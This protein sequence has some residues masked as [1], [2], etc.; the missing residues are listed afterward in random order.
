MTDGTPACAAAGF[1]GDDLSFCRSGNAAQSAALDRCDRVLHVAWTGDVPG[2]YIFDN[3]DLFDE[4]LYGAK[5]MN[6]NYDSIR[7]YDDAEASQALKRVAEAPELKAISSFLYGPGHEFEDRLRSLLRNLDTIDRFQAMIMADTIQTILDKTSSGLHVSGLE[8][9]ENGRKHVL[10]SNHRDIILDPAILQLILFNN[11]MSTTEIAVGDNLIANSFIEDIFRSNRMIK[12]ER[13]G[14]PREKYMSSMRLS[15]YMRDKV[16]SGDCSVWIAQRNGRSKDGRDMT[17]QGLLK[18]LEMSGTGDFVKDFHELAI[19][20]IAVSYQFEPCDFLKARELYISRRCQYVK[21]PGED[22]VSILTGVRQFK[23]RISFRFCPELS[24]E[25]LYMCAAHD[26]NG[27]FKVM[28]SL[29]DDRICT[30]YKLWDTNYIACDI[31]DGSDAYSSMYTPESRS[32]FV[33]YMEK[34]L[35][36]IVGKDPDVDIEELRDIYLSIYANPVRSSR[37]HRAAGM[38]SSAPA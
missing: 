2:I 22:T 7:P 37:E 19:L 34:G 16:A 12:V 21:K 1:S 30:G 10:L 13:G 20:P 26:K 8:N 23:G 24:E 14:T 35:S 11:R 28:A 32:A 36:G 4:V 29:I 38:G 25:E 27:R 15:S 5:K 31:L 9:V 18:M 3:D 33:E 17:E 6:Q